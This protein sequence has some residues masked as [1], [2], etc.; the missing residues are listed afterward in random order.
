MNT[1]SWI[2]FFFLR[3]VC[4]CVGVLGNDRMGTEPRGLKKRESEIEESI[5]REGTRGGRLIVREDREG[6]ESM[7]S[8]S[9]C[10]DEHR[11][12]AGDVWAAD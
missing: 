11:G 4:V 6:F 1:F 10:D 12:S 2:F 9:D 8:E 3:G 7:V 5:G